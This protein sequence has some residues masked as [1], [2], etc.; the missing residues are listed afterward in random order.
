MVEEE[1]RIEEERNFR[2]TFYLMAKN[3]SQLVI[4]LEKVEDRN[5]EGQS[6]THWNDGEEPPPSPSGGEGSS[7]PHHHN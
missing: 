5:L 2:K 6:S 4:R 3:I 7:S 1:A